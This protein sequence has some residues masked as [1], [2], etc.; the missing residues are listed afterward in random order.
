MLPSDW[1]IG[2]LIYLANSW[3]REG[4]GLFSH[5]TQRNLS[6][7]MDFAIAQSIFPYVKDGIQAMDELRIGLKQILKS[8]FTYSAAFVDNLAQ[9]T[10]NN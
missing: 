9:T 5:S 3:T 10:Y 1:L 6:L 4:I 8:R 7:A 2:V